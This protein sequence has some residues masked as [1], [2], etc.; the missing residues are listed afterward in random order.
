MASKPSCRTCGGCKYKGKAKPLFKNEAGN[1]ILN[2]IKIITGLGLDDLPNMPGHICMTCEYHLDQAISFR[3]RCIRTHEI[4]SSIN[5]QSGKNSEENLT[6]LSIFDKTDLNYHSNSIEEEHENNGTISQPLIDKSC[7]IVLDQKDVP[8]ENC[9]TPN[10]Q[11]EAKSSKH[12]NRP[13]YPYK[14]LYC[15]K[16]FKSTII[17]AKHHRAHAGERQYK[18]KLCNMSFEQARYLKGH[19]DSEG[20]QNKMAAG[21]SILINNQNT[22]TNNRNKFCANPPIEYNDVNNSN[23]FDNAFEI[24]LKTDQTQNDETNNL[25]AVDP[26]ATACEI[27][28]APVKNDQQYNLDEEQSN[29]ASADFENVMCER[30]QMGKNRYKCKYCDKRFSKPSNCRAHERVHTGERPFQCENCDVSFKWKQSLKRHINSLGHQNN[31]GFRDDET[32]CKRNHK[33][34]EHKEVCIHDTEG[35]EKSTSLQKLLEFSTGKEENTCKTV[36]KVDQQSVENNRCFEEHEDINA[37]TLDP[38]DNVHESNSAISLLEGAVLERAEEGGIRYNCKYCGKRFT[39]PSNCRAHERV[40]TGERPFICEICDVSFKWKQSLQR[41][42]NSLEHQNNKSF[43]SE[44]TI[45]LKEKTNVQVNQSHKKQTW[46]ARNAA[47]R[48][49]ITMSYY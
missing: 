1:E 20:H 24:F 5:I 28:K 21:N 25:A 7:V 33:N 41:H 9:V 34:T 43:S 23:R 19:I 37:A 35:E 40:H 42:I 32:K 27:V 48:Q 10:K 39:K 14:C 45:T 44:N 6:I 11:L 2:Y 15:E 46:R 47:R 22:S 29:E 12:Q 3:E 13:V 31:E 49:K 18:C 36:S 17:R 16:Q 4:F 8:E 38:T 30:A 26:I